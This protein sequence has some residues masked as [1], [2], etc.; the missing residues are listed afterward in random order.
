MPDR[1]FRDVG[2]DTLRRLIAN[3]PA[4]HA[5]RC[6]GCHTAQTPQPTWPCG[7]RTLA[8]RELTNRREQP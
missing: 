3:H 8:E 5:G 6:A 4:D 1:P 2:S 7:L